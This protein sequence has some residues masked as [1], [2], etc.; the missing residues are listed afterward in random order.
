LTKSTDPYAAID[1]VG[2][3]GKL[4]EV[5]RRNCKHDRYGTI[6]IGKNKVDYVNENGNNAAFVWSFDD[7]HYYMPYDQAVWAD[8]KVEAFQRQ[9]RG[10]PSSMVVHVPTRLLQRVL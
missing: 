4:V 3:N 6:I 7:G 1:F 9:G 8:F 5:K 10:D 2:D